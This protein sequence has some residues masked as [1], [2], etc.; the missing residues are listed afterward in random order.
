MLTQLCTAPSIEDKDW[1]LL[2]PSL[3]SRLLE[4]LASSIRKGKRKQVYTE[5]IEKLNCLLAGS[6]II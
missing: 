2:Y 6:T 5:L 3:F 1:H 4:F